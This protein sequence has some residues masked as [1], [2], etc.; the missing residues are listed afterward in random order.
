[1]REVAKTIPDWL[2]AGMDEVRAN[3]ARTEYPMVRFHFAPG[4]VLDTIPA[5]AP[6]EIALLRLDTD[7]YKSSAHEL[8]HLYSGSGATRRSDYR[9]LRPFPRR[10]RGG[11]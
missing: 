6:N 8:A 4:D 2:K 1:M 3:V 5:Q 10:T 9:W 7:W 11:R